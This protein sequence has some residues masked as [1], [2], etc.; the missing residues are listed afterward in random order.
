MRGWCWA[1]AA[2]AMEVPT[3]RTTADSMKRDPMHVVVCGAGPAGLLCAI[4]L[5]R[6][7]V[8]GAPPLFTVELVEAGEDYGVLDAEGLTKKRSWMIA[9]NGPGLNLPMQI[10]LVCRAESSLAIAV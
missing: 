7:N 1:A 2:A 4:N 5:L 8:P 6:R 10:W 3:T 9:T